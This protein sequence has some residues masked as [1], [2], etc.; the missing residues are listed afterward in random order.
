MLMGRLFG[1]LGGGICKLEDGE[2]VEE[3]QV[4]GVYSVVCG[5][6]MNYLIGG[7]RLI[8]CHIGSTNGK[9]TGSH[10]YLN[11]GE[12]MASLAERGCT[13]S[14]QL[15]NLRKLLG[16]SLCIFSYVS[17]ISLTTLLAS[18]R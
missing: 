1:L 11:L 18:R 2:E 16:Y 7:F 3:G 10:L 12:Y 14:V 4:G 5:R 13:V 6:V 17:T 15:S 8:S 9:G